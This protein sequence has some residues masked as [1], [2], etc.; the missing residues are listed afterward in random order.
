MKTIMSEMKNTQD[1]IHWWWD[2]EEKKINEFQDTGIESMQN[3]TK[4]E[5]K[6]LENWKSIIDLWDNSSGLIYR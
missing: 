3:E 2:M 6:N 1:R 4:R 5:K